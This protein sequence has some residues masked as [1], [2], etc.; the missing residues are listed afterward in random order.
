MIF[1]TSYKDAS[2]MLSVSGLSPLH[3]KEQFYTQAFK[4]L[5]IINNKLPEIKYTSWT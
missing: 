2:M 1:A 3:K 5:N 4:R